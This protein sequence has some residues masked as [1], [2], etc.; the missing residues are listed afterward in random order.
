MKRNIMLININHCVF[1]L[2]EI[3]EIF[4]S[5]NLTSCKYR[6]Y[7]NSE[8]SVWRPSAK[9]FRLA[10]TSDH[11]RIGS[12]WKPLTRSIRTTG[13]IYS[14]ELVDQ[15]TLRF[16]YTWAQDLVTTQSTRRGIIMVVI[17]SQ[18][19]QYLVS[20]NMMLRQVPEV[21]FSSLR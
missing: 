14:N 20:G 2:S 16:I 1:Y 12:F 15:N 17:Q 6:T 7:S 10:F 11:F 8:C 3:L 19:D 4:L 13:D 21:N 9:Y 18:Q 5:R